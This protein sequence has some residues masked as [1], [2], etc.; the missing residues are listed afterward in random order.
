M[1]EDFLLDR[2]E[3]Q[4]WTVN[5]RLVD[6]AGID[7]SEAAQ[8][9]ESETETTCP[10]S[11]FHNATKALLVVAS[12]YGDGDPPNHATEFADWLARR[13]HTS[14]TNVIPPFAVFGLG[15]S[16]YA[17]YCA[18]AKYIDAHLGDGRRLLPL[19]TG[20]AARGDQS[21]DFQQWCGRVVVALQ[22][23]HITSTLR[24][25]KAIKKRTSFPCGTGADWRHS[26]IQRGSVTARLTG[27]KELIQ[28]R[29]NSAPAHHPQRSVLHV[30]LS[31]SSRLVPSD[32]QPG[33]HVG[34]YPRNE[35]EVVQRALR[36]LGIDAHTPTKIME[37]QQNQWKDRDV[38]AEELLITHVNLAGRATPSVLRSLLPFV[39]TLELRALARDLT[40]VD[41]DDSTEHVVT[42]PPKASSTTPA[43]S[44][45][46]EEWVA[47]RRLTVLDLAILFE[48]R[49]S[50]QAFARACGPMQPRLYSVV[51]G[52]SQ[53]QGIIGEAMTVI[54]LCMAV[55]EGGL[56]TNYVANLKRTGGDGELTVFF[57]SSRFRFVTDG[58]PALLV[59][60]GSGVG[61]CVGF[62]EEEI[63]RLGVG[64]NVQPS[65]S[66]PLSHIHLFFGCRTTVDVLYRDR[67]SMFESL[68][69]QVHYAFS[70][71]PGEPK[72]HVQDLIRREAETD[73]NQLLL[74]SGRIY[75]CGRLELMEGVKSAYGC[76]S[77]CW[78]GQ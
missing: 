36:W 17:H 21:H 59:A 6:E 57:R 9:V 23:E 26:A 47:G 12:T 27:A 74:C 78:T 35:A 3:E 61:P 5:A 66:R 62:I 41:T 13:R 18:F 31:V 48:C 33:D 71:V 24:V 44:S 16:T 64:K 32:L 7:W 60:A 45:I 76:Q 46:F 55:A 63:D 11:V 14:N 39:G 25:T 52:K 15:D 56:C 28:Q 51:S 2:L 40:H 34:I 20:D 30:S 54:G 53:E 50:L 73:W 4:G 58:S 10:S 75:V 65:N 8:K 67:L 38:S 22:E 37:W 43:S 29:F 72:V 77:I 19:C 42:S 1:V 69:V 49:P 68:G 70:R